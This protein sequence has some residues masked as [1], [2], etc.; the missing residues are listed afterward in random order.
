[1]RLRDRSAWWFQ[2]RELLEALAIRIHLHARDAD[3]AR[4]RFT[5]GLALA[6]ASDTYGAAWLVADVA[7]PLAA[8]GAWP[9]REQLGR[10]AE[11]A[12][13]LDYAPLTARYGVL[14]EQSGPGDAA[15][16]PSLASVAV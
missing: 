13:E 2:G 3:A 7:G 14:I 5:D 6:E 15:S 11:L 12:K 10:F 16:S 9:E 8:V 1:M 4:L